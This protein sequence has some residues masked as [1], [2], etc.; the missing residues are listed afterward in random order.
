MIEGPLHLLPEP[1]PAT[2]MKPTINTE[3][4]PAQSNLPGLE[5]CTSLFH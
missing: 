3:V 1:T 5:V 4:N 2:Q